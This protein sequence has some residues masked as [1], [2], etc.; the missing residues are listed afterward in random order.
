MRARVSVCVCGHENYLNLCS[1]LQFVCIF[2]F[3]FCFS[4]VNTTPV[5]S[6]A[7]S[8]GVKK[9]TLIPGD[10]IGPE[11]SAAVQKIFTA[12]NVPIEWEAVDVTP[13]RVSI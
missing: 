5:A 2:V 6:R 9:V 13:V 1:Q 7:Y 10:G 4:Q 12:A 8:S 3:V 11:I